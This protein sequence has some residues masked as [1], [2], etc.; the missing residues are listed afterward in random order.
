V[1]GGIDGCR[2]VVDSWK[3]REDGKDVDAGDL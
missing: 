1:S 3:G 2:W